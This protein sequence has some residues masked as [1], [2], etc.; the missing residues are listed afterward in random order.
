M[1]SP[2]SLRSR[3]ARRHGAGA[4][5]DVVEHHAAHVGAGGLAAEVEAEHPGLADRELAEL[6]RHEARRVM[7]AVEG[8]DPHHDLV[9]RLVEAVVH[10]EDRAAA[11]VGLLQVVQFDRDLAGPGGEGRSRGEKE[12]E[13][14]S[15]SEERHPPS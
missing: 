8:N 9:E 4:G 2:P 7:G 11:G 3:A 1:L 15:G 14:E 13:G 6:E 10:H 12:K 5:G